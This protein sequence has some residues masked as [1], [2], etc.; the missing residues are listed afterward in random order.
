MPERAPFEQTR[1]PAARD[2][3]K[4]SDRSGS[5]HRLKWHGLSLLLVVILLGGC[6]S[7]PER[8]QPLPAELAPLAEI[9]GIP[10]ARQWG[11]RPPEGLQAWMTLPE[12]ELRAGYGEIMD[13]PHSYLV[14]S[15]GG[16]DGAFGAGVLVGWSARGDRPEFQIV[17]G[18]S[19]GALIAPFAF[20]G[21]DYDAV[22]QEAYTQFSTADLSERRSLIDI[23]RG[24]AAADV[25]GLRRVLEQ[26][27]NDE[28]IEAIAAEHRKGK[29][30]YIGTTNIDA[31]RPV[32]W[33]ITRIAASGAANAPELIREV[34]IAST[35]IPGAF[36]PVML[37]VQAN[38]ESYDEMHVDGGVT[39]QLFLGYA[40]MDWGR[41]ARRLQVVGRP[42]V[43]AIRNAKLQQP[44]KPVPRRLPD[45]VSRSV[46]TLIRSQGLGDLAK[47]Y[48]VA[49]ENGFDY[50]VAYIPDD[51]ELE[52]TE[53]FDREYMRE[54]FKLGYERANEGKAW[55]TALGED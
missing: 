37:E 14:I 24:D 30:L 40:G 36:P 1:Q 34:I 51:F 3:Q 25:A 23:V 48:V 53:A 11:D 54:L 20:L 32:I 55:T 41:I 16:G 18:I 50:Q 39:A 10:G 17:S 38:G 33:G 22:L 15:G 8:G 46:S 29:T 19:T 12:S 9:P 4:V 13:Q 52:S 47:L 7:P 31:A 45:V 44:W 35:A 42:T 26:Y 49:R 5:Q 6:A 2:R 21:P 28:V 27:L 43:Y